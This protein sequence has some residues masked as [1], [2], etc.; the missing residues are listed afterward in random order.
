[1]VQV[2]VVAVRVAVATVGGDVAGDQIVLL[3]EV[4][5]IGWIVLDVVV[6]LQIVDLG[7]IVDF[8]ALVVVGLLKVVQRRQVLLLLLAD[9]TRSAEA[10]TVLR[11]RN[12]GQCVLLAHTVVIRVVLLVDAV[13]D[14]FGRHI[15]LLRGE[16]FVGWVGGDH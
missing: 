11:R 6:V 13:A 14:R 2:V 5:E 16:L 7:E 12:V 15:V 3:R 8:L 1:M 9:A 4:D 10:V